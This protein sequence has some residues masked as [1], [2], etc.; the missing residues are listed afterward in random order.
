MPDNARLPL[1]IPYVALASS[2]GGLWSLAYSGRSKCG[3][4]TGACAGFRR[5]TCGPCSPR[6]CSALLLRADAVVSADDLIDRVRG[7][8]A[9]RRPRK[10]LHV[11]VARAVRPWP[12][13]LPAYQDLHSCVIFAL[14]PRDRAADRVTRR[15]ALPCSDGVTAAFLNMRVQYVIL[16]LPIKPSGPERAVFIRM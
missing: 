1:R 14:Q 10:A 15:G 12:R 16:L 2:G 8:Q 11:M 4:T 3:A 13:T 5:A 7:G 9:P 6:S